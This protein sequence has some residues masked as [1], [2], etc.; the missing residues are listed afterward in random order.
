MVLRF[1][2][3]NGIDSVSEFFKLGG[4]HCIRQGQTGSG[5]TKEF[6]QLAKLV[7]DK[8]KKILIMT[9]RAEILYQAGGSI[10]EIGLNTIYIQAGAK[11]V[12]N[13]FNVYVAMSQTLRRRI[14]LEYWILFL[15]SIDLLIVDEC[16][17]QDFNY[18]FESQIFD[19]IHTIG[20]TATPKRTGKSR[21]LALDYESIIEGISVKELIKLDYLVNDD[22]Y[23]FGAPDL[24]D[25]EFDH[26]KGDYKES[27]LFQKFNNPKTYSGAVKNYKE[28]APNTK[29][30]CFCINIEHCIKTAIAFN[31]AGIDAKFIVSNISAPK[32]PEDV[33]DLGKMARYEER[34][35]VYNL[36]QDN[37]HLTGPRKTIFQDFRNN[38]FK[39]LIN[40]GI[41]TTGYDEPS[42]ETVIVLRATLSTTLWL[43]MLGRGSR[44][45]ESKTHFNIL[46][47]GGNADRLGH[48]TEDR[49]WSLWHEKFEGEG[50]P[51]IKNCGIDSFGKPLSGEKGCKRP[52]LASYKICPFCGYKYPDKIHKEI[53]LESIMF[54]SQRKM[55]VKTKRIK[56]MT[57]QELYNY[58]KE[59]GHRTPWLWRM[60]WYRNQEKSIKEFGLLFGWSSAGIDK[61][62]SF[63]K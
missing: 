30:I 36:L 15:Q 40:A 13:A 44:I 14:H 20:F 58:W 17:S 21:Q 51:P 8:N 60:L 2:Q 9:N 55:S 34:L 25:V 46:D 1:Y 57:Y 35:R 18:L 31:D 62:I 49:L 27:S 22:Y 42:I 39:I 33:L 59:K 10:K 24:S 45:F 56:D 41:A 63:M 4:L 28:I 61:G 23:G 48:Y 53:D 26:L 54:D 37:K 12:S 52:I 7:S 32:K 6:T 16:H 47:F 5:K 50:L 43:Q 38:K 29:A 19:N 3:Q 11:I